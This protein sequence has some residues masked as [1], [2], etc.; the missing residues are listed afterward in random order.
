MSAGVVAR[1]DRPAAVVEAEPAR[2]AGRRQR[3]VARARRP[4]SAPT[5]AGRTSRARPPMTAGGRLARHSVQRGRP[6]RRPAGSRARSTSSRAM[7]RRC[8]PA[9]AARERRGRWREPRAAAPQLEAADAGQGGE[10]RR[11]GGEIVGVEDAAGGAEDDAVGERPDAPQRQRGAMRSRRQ[12]GTAPSSGE[13]QGP[14]ELRGERGRGEP[15]GPDRH[16]VVG[17]EAAA[18]ALGRRPAW[19]ARRAGARS[20]RARYGRRSARAWNCPR[21]LPA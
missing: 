19:R 17:L 5:A 2:Q 21:L 13:R 8:R 18:P 6:Q 14:G 11:Q 12:P 15:Q 1:Q 9:R 3:E 10:R 7:R 4:R 16:G 20:A